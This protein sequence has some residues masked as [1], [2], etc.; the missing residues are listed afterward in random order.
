MGIAKSRSD[1]KYIIT[2]NKIQFLDDFNE[3]LDDY[4]V[5]INKCKCLSFGKNRHVSNFNQQIIVPI[6]VLGLYLNSV[7]N[8]HIVLSPNLIC[9]W[10]DGTFNK[11]IKLNRKLTFLRFTCS[12]DESLHLPKYLKHVRLNYGS[13]HKII[14]NKYISELDLTVSENMFIFTKLPKELTEINIMF[15]THMS[16]DLKL[17]KNLK[18]IQMY[19]E[20]WTDS[21]IFPKTIKKVQLYGVFTQKLILTPHMA[22]LYLSTMIGT[23]NKPHFEK[24]LD[25]LFIE[26]SNYYDNF[27]SIDNLPNGFKRVI[28]N[29]DKRCCNHNMPN[30]IKTI[31]EFDY[32][33]DYDDHYRI[34]LQHDDVPIEEDEF[35]TKNRLYKQFDDYWNIPTQV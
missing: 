18:L 9:I 7:F 32:D 31:S 10:I 6:N 22:K 23:F 3:P 30:D 25:S 1:N 20:H 27:W 34:E 8:Q 14:L 13:S 19:A 35:L 17:P 26:Y 15:H 5:T 4:Y 21:L 33:S 24:P 29:L 16:F 2:D 11:P 28:M 12:Y